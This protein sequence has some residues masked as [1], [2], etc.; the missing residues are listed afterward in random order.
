QS[1]QTSYYYYDLILLR[2]FSIFKLFHAFHGFYHIQLL[3]LEM[4]KD[5]YQHG[6]EESKQNAV[7]KTDKFNISAKHHHIHFRGKNYKT[8]EY[9]ADQ[10]T[11]CRSDNRQ[12]H[13]FPEN[14]LGNLDIIK[15]QNFQSCQFPPAF[16][17]IDV[18]Q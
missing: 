13:I 1:I 14:I 9:K 2:I 8:V 18:I 4:H 16:T 3:Q 6:K 5:I 12:D 10:H 17:D 7:Q 15:S 11:R